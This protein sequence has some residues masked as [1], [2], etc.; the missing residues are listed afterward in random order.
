MALP[1]AL[2]PTDALRI[3]HGGQLHTLPCCRLSFPAAPATAGVHRY[4]NK[5]LVLVDG[6]PQFAEFAIL[7]LFEAAGWEGRWVITWQHGRNPRL[8]RSWDP[9][10]PKAQVHEPIAAPWVNARLRAIAAANGG[11]YGGCWDVVAW[12]RDAAGGHRLVFAESKRKGSDRIRPTQLRWHQA[13]LAC[14]CA[15]EDFV[16]V[17]WAVG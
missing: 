15:A 6:R 7:R 14:G 5:P 16:V 13:A 8:W 10:G 2:H 4:G 12:T 3:A 1:A 17:E 9:A 11:T